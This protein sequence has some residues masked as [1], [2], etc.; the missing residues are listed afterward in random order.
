MKFRKYF[1]RELQLRFPGHHESVRREVESRYRAILPDVC[2][3]RSSPNPVDR[4]L[5]FSAYFLATI[6]TLEARGE[7]FAS[8]R[9]VC[10]AIVREYVRPKSPWQRWLRRVPVT[11]IR[12]PLRRI[13]VRILRAKIQKKGHPD[14]FLVH[15]VTG[16]DETFGLGYGFNVVE[17][18]ICKLFQKHGAA[19]YTAILCD[20]DELTSG[21]AGLDLVR[22]GTIAR[23]APVCDFRFRIQNASGPAARTMST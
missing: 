2:F 12:T 22:S 16:A 3:A 4:R 23:G 20:V 17:C 6:L 8:I 7:D 13:L 10:L 19:R 21:F 18:G 5:D 9:N 1:D 11:L 15:I 14:G